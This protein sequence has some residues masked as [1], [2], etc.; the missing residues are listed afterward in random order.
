M[1]DLQ[2]AATLLVVG[3]DPAMPP[4]LPANVA[5]VYCCAS[6]RER[7]EALALAS[8]TPLREDVGLAASDPAGAFEAIADLHRGE[9]VLVLPA[10]TPARCSATGITR[11]RIDG[12]GWAYG[13]A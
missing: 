7:A 9:T 2:C 13:D 4:S 12:D 3:A 11:L 6:R 1:S 10:H 8:G 5:L